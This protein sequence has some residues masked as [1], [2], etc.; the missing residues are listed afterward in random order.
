MVTLW[1]VDHDNLLFIMDCLGALF[2]EV[3]VVYEP[4]LVLKF[5]KGPYPFDA[6]HLDSLDW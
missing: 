5:E 6:S 3:Q 2:A 4:V 1:L